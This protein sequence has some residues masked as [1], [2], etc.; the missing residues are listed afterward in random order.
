LLSAVNGGEEK[1]DDEQEEDTDG[2]DDL[3][4]TLT[5][6]LDEENS[7]FQ[8]MVPFQVEGANNDEDSGSTSCSATTFC[9][10]ESSCTAALVIAL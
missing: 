1:L 5:R 10:P 3:K 8:S 4:R 2:E 7:S 9:K 6:V